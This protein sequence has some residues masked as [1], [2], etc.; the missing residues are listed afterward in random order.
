MD[1]VELN[2]QLRR[3]TDKTSETILNA[4]GINGPLD[5]GNSFSLSI[6]AK[7]L[8]GA[9]LEGLTVKVFDEDHVQS[10]SCT[11][12]DTQGQGR[13]PYQSEIELTA[14]LKPGFYRWI[15]ELEN[16]DG[17]PISARPLPFSVSPRT[18][19]KVFVK[20]VDDFTGEPLDNCT[21]FFYNDDLD[22][23]A[24]TS[25]E[26]D[27]GGIAATE[28]ADGVSY[29]VCCVREDYVQAFHTIPAGSDAYE[30]LIEMRSKL[31]LKIARPLG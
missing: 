17:A 14:P 19:R 3:T 21:V 30:G 11:L 29:S 7:N 25:V 12:A 5:L 18:S 23:T 22:K 8:N 2:G 15:I 10:G 24:P 16:R 6:G 31:R 28:I 4:W 9:S 1:Q 27:F 20:V 13:A 26:T